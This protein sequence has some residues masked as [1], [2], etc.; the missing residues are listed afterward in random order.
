M[1]DDL[2]ASVTSTSLSATPSCSH[3]NN[4]LK[5]KGVAILTKRLVNGDMEERYGR[6]GWANNL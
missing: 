2:L 5:H 4:S 3:G 6:E 1:P